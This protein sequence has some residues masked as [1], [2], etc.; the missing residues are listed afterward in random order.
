[1]PELDNIMQQIADAGKAGD[2]AKIKSLTK[3]ANELEKAEDAAKAS[4]RAQESE[5]FKSLVGEA[6]KELAKL[7]KAADELGI[8]KFG[9][10]VS[11][12]AEGKWT[13]DVVA[14][15]KAR[16]GG[17]GGGK[18]F[19][20]STEEMLKK[21]GSHKPENWDMTLQQKYDSTKDGNSR[22]AV[23]KVCLKLEGLM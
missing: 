12:N 20:V 9:V 8:K 17:G 7:T 1:M 2:L 22:Y 21:H 10:V 13:T 16:T 18:R 11:Q 15:A 5:A 19:S 6:G 14:G 23:R 3:Q 4:R